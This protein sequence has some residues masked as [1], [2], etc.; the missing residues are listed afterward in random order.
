MARQAGP[1]GRWLQRLIGVARHRQVLVL[2]SINHVWV[3]SHSHC[4]ADSPFLL[5]TGCLS[6][7]D[8]WSGL[9]NRTI[10]L[11][12][13]LCTNPSLSSSLTT[14]EA[15]LTA[16]LTSFTSMPCRPIMRRLMRSAPGQ[17]S[18]AAAMS[19]E[20]AVE[21]LRFCFADLWDPDAPAA[22]RLTSN[23]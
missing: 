14:E 11:K 19:P 20:E 3:R 16:T 15:M 18:P 7:F 17:P 23:Y 5:G 22:V 9:S 13:L 2:G 12:L 4:D 6:A 10:W 1:R 21:M 8:A